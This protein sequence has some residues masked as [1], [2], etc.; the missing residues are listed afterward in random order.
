MSSSPQL[1]VN[2]EDALPVCCTP[3]AHIAL[4][5]LLAGMTPAERKA[6]SR[7]CVA[8]RAAAS[9]PAAWASLSAGHR[10]FCTAAGAASE[11]A[12][13]DDCDFCAAAATAADE[14]AS[15]EP[16][17]LDYRRAHARRHLLQPP[18]CKSA[19]A[20]LA[21]TGAC[22]AG[23]RALHLLTRASGAQRK[24]SSACLIVPYKSLVPMPSCICAR[25]TWSTLFLPP[26]SACRRLC[27][28]LALPELC[29][30]ASTR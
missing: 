22:R 3:R 29:S 16:M 6:C 30:A 23:G 28:V 12:A 19:V 18:A 7:V 21:L 11:R 9:D 27:D 15:S 4:V 8:W 13:V 1:V 17:L 5:L 14:A 26:R 10:G 24:A 25:K 2:D 20:N